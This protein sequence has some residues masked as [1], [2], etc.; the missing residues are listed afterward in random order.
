MLAAGTRAFADAAES[1]CAADHTERRRDQYAADRPETGWSKAQ[2]RGVGH[3]LV[4]PTRHVESV[5]GLSAGELGDLWDS[6]ARG[7]TRPRRGSASVGMASNSQ[8]TA[9]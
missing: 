4:V 9:T 5:F 7:Q 3:T 6:G 1:V 2:R 8:D